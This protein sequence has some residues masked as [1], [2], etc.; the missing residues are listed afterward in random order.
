MKKG[1]LYL[2]VR[3][4]GW[5]EGTL[6][7]CVGLRPYM[8]DGLMVDGKYVNFIAVEDVVEIGEI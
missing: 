6:L 8:T 5:E 4:C 7:E 1:Y 2:V 3:N